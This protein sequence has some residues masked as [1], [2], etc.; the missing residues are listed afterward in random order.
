M[1]AIYV[2]ILAVWVMRIAFLMNSDGVGSEM[3]MGFAVLYP[4]YVCCMMSVV[5]PYVRAKRATTLGS[6]SPPDLENVPL[7]SGRAWWP[8][9]VAPHGRGVGVTAE[10][11]TIPVPVNCR[12]GAEA[13]QAI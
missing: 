4:C 1:L 11:C 2:I 13:L 12:Y 5:T 3:F 8:T 9:V 6:Q 7:S 10:H